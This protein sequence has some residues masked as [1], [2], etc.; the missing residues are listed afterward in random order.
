VEGGTL[1]RPLV[2][3]ALGLWAVDHFPELTD[4]GTMGESLSEQGLE[5]T[6]TPDPL[7]R[8]RLEHQR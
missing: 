2:D 8:D 7:H 3:H 6:P 1:E 4:H 5:V